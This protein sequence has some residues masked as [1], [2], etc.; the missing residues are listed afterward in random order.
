[1]PTWASPRI[2]SRGQAVAEQQ[3]VGGAY[4]GG[5]LAAAGGVAARWRSRGTPSTTA[6]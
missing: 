5:G 1:M 4:G 6:R 2:A 3:V